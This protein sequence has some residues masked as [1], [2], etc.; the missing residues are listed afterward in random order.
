MTT[1]T[2]DLRAAIKARRR[3]MDAEQR[4][5]LAARE[6]Q[7][8]TER[9]AR[10]DRFRDD[11]ERL[12][13]EEVRAQLGELRYEIDINGPFAQFAIT[14]IQYTVR[15]NGPSAL[16]INP[17]DRYGHKRQLD[18]YGRGDVRVALIDYLAQVH[19]ELVAEQRERERRRH[20]DAEQRRVLRETEAAIIAED[21][22]CQALIAEQVAAAQAALWQW[23]EGRTLAVYHWRWATSAAAGGEGADYDDA[24]ASSPELTPDGWLW[25]LTGRRLNLGL[26]R[27]GPVVEERTFSATAQLPDALRRDVRV[28]ITGF[29]YADTY[30]DGRCLRRACAAGEQGA[31]FR[32]TV[33][34]E[35]IDIVKLLLEG[36]A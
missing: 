19:P 13:P 22:R 18:A 32:E 17:W 26:L 28:T 10:L 6:F 14:G 35:P 24:W 12:I 11:I 16:Y 23:P 25:T 2:F 33:G 5:Q 1:D 3:Q 36:K 21:A 29:D 9:S 27:P 31:V 15:L 7:Q 20:E 34:E 4:Q 30:V 8:A